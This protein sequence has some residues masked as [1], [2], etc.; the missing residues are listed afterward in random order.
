MPPPL[1]PLKRAWPVDLLAASPMLQRLY[2]EASFLNS[3]CLEA[4]AFKIPGCSPE[5]RSWALAAVITRNFALKGPSG[6]VEA[7]G[8][9][10]FIDLFNHQSCHEVGRISWTCSFQERHGCVVMVADRGIAKGEPLTFRYIA[11]PD[12][13][14]LVQYGIPPSSRPNSQ[15]MAGFQVHSDVLDGTDKGCGRDTRAEARRTL[16]REW[17]WTDQTQPLL[18]TIPEARLLQW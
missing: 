4:L 18:F 8:L 1:H 16:A 17:G 13:A 5:L 14:L 2:R 15:D 3:R 10:P 6:K 9:L 12:A 7:L 11:A